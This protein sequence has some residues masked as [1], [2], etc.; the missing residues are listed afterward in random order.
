MKIISD[1]RQIPKTVEYTR[2]EGY[3]DYLYAYLQEIS[4]WDGETGH[5]RYL[6]KQQVKFVAMRKE[7]HKSRQ[8]I[9]LHFKSLVEMGLVV[10]TK[11]GYILTILD[12]DLAMLVPVNT[13]RILTNTFVDRVITIYVHLLNRYIA[14][15][16]FNQPTVFT[17]EQLKRVAGLSVNSGN[18]DEK[19]RDI[20]FIL[21]KVGLLRY[22]MATMIEGENIKTPY[23]VTWMTN[24]IEDAKDAYLE[25]C[26]G[27][28][29]VI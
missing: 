29:K 14:N 16:Y 22:K 9:S 20:L 26:K 6:K 27:E 12:S 21:D 25:F 10:E 8:T 18:N 24:N 13:L 1:S 19:I 28:R 15:S 17:Y 7:L 5:P 23:M 11:D 4:F 3:Y 2:A